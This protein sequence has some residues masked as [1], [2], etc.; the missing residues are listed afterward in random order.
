MEL[1]I[2]DRYKATGT[3][4]PDPETMCQGQ[5]EGMGKVPVYEDDPNDEEGNWHDL[6]LAAEAKTPS[7]DDCHFVVCPR[8]KGTKLEPVGIPPMQ[9]E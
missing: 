1:E 8:C 3:P 7:D 4:Y 9:G 5:C 2:T 6:W